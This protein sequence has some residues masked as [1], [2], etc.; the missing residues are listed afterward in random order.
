MGGRPDLAFREA[1]ASRR[2]GGPAGR[3]GQIR[4]AR[5]WLPVESAGLGP[6]G[7]A[8]LRAALGSREKRPRACLFAPAKGDCPGVRRFHGRLP[9]ASR[10]RAPSASRRFRAAP[11]RVVGPRRRAGGEILGAAAPLAGPAAAGA[12]CGGSRRRPGFRPMPPA[13]PC[14][15]FRPGRLRPRLGRLAPWNARHIPRSARLAPGSERLIP[16]SARLAPGNAR[17]IPRSARL[18]PGSERLTPGNARLA[19]GSERLTPGNARHIPGSARLAPGS[20][21]L[22]PGSARLTPG[23]A[24]LAPGSERHIPGSARHIPGNARLIPGGAPQAARGLIPF[25]FNSPPLRAQRRGAGDLLPRRAKMSKR[26]PQSPV[27]HGGDDLFPVAR[28]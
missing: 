27:I 16:R 4:E 12:E 14:P 18:A 26:N 11:P 21:R 8:W 5:A 28:I 3:S 25:G 10:N 20:A 6:A 22:A 2:R 15:C 9:L 1:L 17:H 19:P 13:A 23:N 24:R 7:R